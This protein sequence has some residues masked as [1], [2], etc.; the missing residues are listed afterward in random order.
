MMRIMLVLSVCV[1]ILTAAGTALA[2]DG[3]WLGARVTTGPAIRYDFRA[4]EKSTS[5]AEA[6]VADVIA[7]SPAAAAASEPVT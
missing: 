7:G 1:L 2:Q 4:G 6:K 3:G 5:P